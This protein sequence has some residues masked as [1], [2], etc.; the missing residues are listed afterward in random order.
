MTN[1]YSVFSGKFNHSQILALLCVILSFSK[2]INLT[3]T[4]PEAGLFKT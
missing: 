3:K 4:K 1:L 2:R